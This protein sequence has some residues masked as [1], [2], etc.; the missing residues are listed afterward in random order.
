MC[1]DCNW[2]RLWSFGYDTKVCQVATF[3]SE[4]LSATLKMNAACPT[5]TLVTTCQT[6]C[7]MTRQILTK[8]LGALKTSVMCCSEGP[9]FVL[10]PDIDACFHVCRLKLFVWIYHFFRWLFERIQ[11]WLLALLEVFAIRFKKKSQFSFCTSV[12]LAVYL[13]K[14]VQMKWVI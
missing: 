3:V 2:F 11:I 14:W 5:K 4:K 6:T 8:I 9:N 10:Q 12:V 13:P 7:N 1:Y